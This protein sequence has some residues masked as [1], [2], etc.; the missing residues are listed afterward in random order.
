VSDK[1]K[2]LQ[3]VGRH[4]TGAV[5]PYKSHCALFLANESGNGSL[6]EQRVYLNKVTVNTVDYSEEI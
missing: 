3:R 6:L 2:L 1:D 5:M 4:C